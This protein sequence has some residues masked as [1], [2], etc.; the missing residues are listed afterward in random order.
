MKYTD[1][2][3][4]TFA[5]AVG[6]KAGLTDIIPRECSCNQFIQLAKNMGIWVENDAYTPSA[7]DM[8]LYDWDDNGVG[9]N[10]G[11]ADHIG[12]VVSVSGGVIKVIEG[13]KSNAV[14]YRELAVNG[15]YIRGFVTPKYSS[16]ATKEEAPKPSG[17]GGG[18]YNIGDIV[19]F[20]G[21]LH[22]TSS[23]ASGVAYGCKAGQAKVTNKAEGA[24]HPYHLQAISGKGSTVYGWVNAGDISGKTGGGSAKTYTVVKGDTLSKIAKKYGTTVDTLV[25]LNG[26][27]NK[28]LINIGQ[29]IKLP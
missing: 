10:T 5:S 21:C 27:K 15:K 4:A 14:G 11:S 17:N 20:T 1:A 19:N 28:N 12:I 13:N 29:V 6:I 3:C 2:W 23:T 16:K 25:K 9:D 18:S 26:I 8:I 7:G 24:I 22:Y